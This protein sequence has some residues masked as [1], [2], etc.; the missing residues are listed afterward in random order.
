MTSRERV[1]CTLKHEEPDRVPIVLGASNATGIRMKAYRKLQEHLGV[2]AE[3]RYLYDW[4]ELGTARIDEQGRQIDA[5][6]TTKRAE[7]RSTAS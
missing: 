4:P 3:E 6:L 5:G 2:S 7:A 1:L